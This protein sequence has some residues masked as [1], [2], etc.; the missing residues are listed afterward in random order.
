MGV[1]GEGYAAGRARCVHNDDEAA[2]WKARPL[3]FLLLLDTIR[4]VPYAQ[5]GDLR[6]TSVHSVL[7]PSPLPGFN[8]LRPIYSCYHLRSV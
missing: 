2:P 6:E 7:N 4:V 1:L 5:L 8:P 3:L